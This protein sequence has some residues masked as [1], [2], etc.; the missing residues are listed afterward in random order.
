M[1]H[2]KA[3]AVVIAAGL[4]A[5]LTP[6]AKSGDF[7]LEDD[8]S[9][10]KI[11]TGSPAG[12][13]DWLVDGPGPVDIDHMAKQW[14]WFRVGPSGPEAS[15]DTLSILAEGLSDTNIDGE[16]ETLFVRYEDP[17]GDFQIEIT[18]KVTGG[19]PGQLLSYQ[20]GYRDHQYVRGR[21]GLPLLSV[22]GPRFERHSR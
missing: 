1:R 5:L 8:N 19:A 9:K 17:S 22:C 15:I 14:F 20:G 7:T 10:V 11:N 16:K 2:W 18:F 21:L 13:Y 6:T 4:N 12:Q 3:I